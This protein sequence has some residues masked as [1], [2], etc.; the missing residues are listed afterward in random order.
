[1]HAKNQ[2]S[3]ETERERQRKWLTHLSSLLRCGQ[4]LFIV[5]ILKSFFFFFFFSVF[6]GTK[7][8]CWNSTQ[9]SLMVLCSGAW[10][11]LERYSGSLG[12][13]S[14]TGTFKN[15]ESFRD[16]YKMWQQEWFL[17]R[18]LQSVWAALSVRE[19]TL[20]ECLAYCSPTNTLMPQG[21]RRL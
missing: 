12:Q 5:V 9:L 1:M 21:S 19:Q 7:V 18:A 4:S 13:S 15:A 11:Q 2:S 17:H 8:T 6:K 16:L 20:S 14:T 10:A 3:R